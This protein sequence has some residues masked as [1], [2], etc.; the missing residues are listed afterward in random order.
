MG[1]LAEMETHRLVALIPAR[2]GSKRLPGKNLRELN[3]HPLLAYAIAAAQ[4][5]ELFERIIVSSDDPATRELAFAYGACSW[6]LRPS[7]MARDDSPD[8][9]WINHVVEGSEDQ[10]DAFAILRPTSPFRR[11]PWIRAAWEY[12]LE[13]QPLD[14]LR[15]IRPVREHPAKMWMQHGT[16]LSPVLSGWGTLAPWHSMPTQELPKCYVQTA[17]LEIAWADVAR[18]TISGAAIGCWMT[19]VDA[20][21]AC[22]VNDA[23]DWARVEALA[24]EHP[25]YLP[26][27]RRG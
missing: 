25:E 22:D 27:P 11:G 5:S 14:S 10:F 8:I 15:A 6:V 20:P 12:F 18:S 1:V 23:S 4:E 21:E 3:G 16:H 2:A 7:E 13:H 19:D 24:A 26:V 17:A 9:E